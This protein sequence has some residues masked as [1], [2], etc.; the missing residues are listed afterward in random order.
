MIRSLRLSA[1]ALV[2]AL[3]QPLQASA[4]QQGM[5][6]DLHKQAQQISELMQAGNNTEAATRLAALRARGNL[7][8]YEKAVLS[9]MLGYAHAGA[10]DYPKAIPAFEDALAQ[11][12]LPPEIGGQVS[13]ALVQM[14]LEGRNYEKAR[15]RIEQMVAGGHQGNAD[16]FNVAAYVYLELKDY[17]SA[18]RYAL[19]AISAEEKPRENSYQILLA[20][21]RAQKAWDKA[22]AVLRDVIARFPGEFN[23]WQYLSYALFEQDKENEALAALMLAYRLGI[24]PANELER[25][26]TLHANVGVP[27]KAARLLEQWMRDGEIESNEERLTLTGKLWLVARERDKAKQTLVKAAG[28]SQKPDNDLLVGKLYY[29]DEHWEPAMQHLQAALTKGA[30]LPV[31]AESEKKDRKESRE[32]TRAE[33]QLLLGICAYN[34]RHTETAVSALE[35]ASKSKKYHNHA[36]YWLSRVKDGDS[37]I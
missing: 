23:Y 20:V 19:Q 15:T 35:E 6:A 7:N 13:I 2:I 1:L 3:A 10:G 31:G 21:Y 9:Q 18:E 11:N 25:L 24:L 12:A 33:A 5:S 28:L 30:T 27:E 22:E 32:E 26:A 4:Q 37:R 34:A 29:E 17:G 14:Y 36:K 16:F 8:S